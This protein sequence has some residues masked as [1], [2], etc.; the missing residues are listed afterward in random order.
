MVYEWKF[1][2]LYN[3]SAQAAGAEIEGC[4]NS[5]G[6]ITP[7]AVVEKAKD[8]A[9]VIH[10]CFEWDNDT[11]ADKYRLQQAGEL[12]RNIVTV[13][14]TEDEAVPLT[15][16]AFVNVKSEAERGYKG[17]AAVVTKPDEYAYLLGCAKNE[18]EAFEKKYAVLTELR[19]VFRAI[20]EVLAT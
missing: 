16:R 10:D 20:S 11:A 5:D 7:A 15:V 18:L 4:K 9:S 6:F 13:C 8:E 12:I 3:I 14:K 2:N 17:I 19:S 1:P